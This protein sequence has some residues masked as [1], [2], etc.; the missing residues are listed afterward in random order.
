MNFPLT[1]W[2]L[3]YHHLLPR[4]VHACPLAIALR[5]QPQPNLGDDGV[6]L[7]LRAD[8]PSTP[9]PSHPLLVGPQPDSRE[10]CGGCHK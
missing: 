4:Y 8:F 10:S 3:V 7:I 1:P 2:H 6:C 9:V 5:W